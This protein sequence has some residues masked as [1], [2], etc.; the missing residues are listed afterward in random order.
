MHSPNRFSRIDSHGPASWLGISIP[1]A[2]FGA[3]IALTACDSGGSHGSASV[4][5]ARATDT[6]F[7]Q[8]ATEV[9]RAL[10]VEVAT[11][12]MTRRRADVGVMLATPHA[13]PDSEY[14]T[15]R[16]LAESLWQRSPFGVQADTVAVSVTRV[17]RPDS[18]IERNTYFYYRSER[19]M[20]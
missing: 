12:T 7:R 8:V 15:F 20:P 1:L 14:R 16:Q 3:A 4:A 19:R 5:R 18:V 17:A 13:N 6:T 11:L 10:H 2:L 9:A